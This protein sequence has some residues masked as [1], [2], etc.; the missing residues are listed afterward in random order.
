MSEVLALEDLRN[1]DAWR[2]SIAE[3]I[4]TLC[5]VFIGVGAVVSAGIFLGDDGTVTAGKMLVI[6]MAHGF[7]IAIMVAATGRISGAH[8]NPAVTFSAVI[9]RKIGVTKGGMYVIAQL[10]GAI[11]G[12]FIIKTI[13]PDALEGG[14]GTHALGADISVGAGLLTEMVLTFILVF[15]IFATA[16]DPRGPGNLAP[17]A[18]GMAVMVDIFVGLPL[19]GASM[20]P[21]RTVGPA[22]VAGELANNWLYW[23]GPM[24]GGAIAA[25]IYEYVF[26]RERS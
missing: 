24:A 9:T 19:T 12:A 11:V 23:I 4:A 17:F 7:A 2:A 10:S 16:V 20:N 15:V 3:F 13:I 18:I 8:L 14:L 6:A 5:F 1:W 21:A 25:F 26:L 22:L